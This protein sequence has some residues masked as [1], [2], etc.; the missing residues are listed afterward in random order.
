MA[1]SANKRRFWSLN[2]IGC[3]VLIRRGLSSE[4]N[5][6]WTS[7][8]FHRSLGFIVLLVLLAATVWAEPHGW[9]PKFERPDC[10]FW[11]HAQAVERAGFVRLPFRSLPSHLSLEAVTHSPDRANELSLAPL[12]QFGAN[13]ADAK[14]NPPRLSQIFLAP[15]SV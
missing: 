11:P 15:N 8:W 5:K 14:I 4:K 9:P 6:Y 12:F 2:T 10:H 1:H 3:R 7:G 13:F